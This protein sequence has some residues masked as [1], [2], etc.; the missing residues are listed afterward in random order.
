MILQCG[1]VACGPLGFFH[2]RSFPPENP[3][4][5]KYQSPPTSHDQSSEHHNAQRM[6]G[7]GFWTDLTKVL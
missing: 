7:R 1:N 3:G 5:R 6:W 2:A 4:H